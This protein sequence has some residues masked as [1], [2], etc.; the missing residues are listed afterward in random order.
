[1]GRAIRLPELGTIVPRVGGIGQIHQHLV[2]SNHIALGQESL[3][4]EHTPHLREFFLYPARVEEGVYRTPQ[5]LGIPCDL[6]DAD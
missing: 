2:L 3:F 1:M 6:K 4:L 5:E